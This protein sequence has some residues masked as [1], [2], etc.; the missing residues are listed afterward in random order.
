MARKAWKEGFLLHCHRA[1]SPSGYS[2]MQYPS[3]DPKSAQS[4][5]S[6][7][8]S[9]ACSPALDLVRRDCRRVGVNF[10]RLTRQRGNSHNSMY[11]HST[12]P[13]K[14]C[15]PMVVSLSPRLDARVG[16][17]GRASRG[18]EWPGDLPLPSS[19]SPHLNRHAQSIAHNDCHLSTH[20]SCPRP[21]R[22]QGHLEVSWC[23]YVQVDTVDLQCQGYRVRE[24]LWCSQVSC[25]ESP[26][27]LSLLISSC[28]YS[29]LPVVIDR[30]LGAK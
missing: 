13:T 1:D 10:F 4:H 3:T 25:F 29:P 24:C 26:R 6:G 14:I 9:F 28:S 22:P 18:Y 16:A 19:L 8:I 7:L 27:P 21:H 17:G 23:Q 11:I 12:L 30:G 2:S 5:A 20:L 15:T